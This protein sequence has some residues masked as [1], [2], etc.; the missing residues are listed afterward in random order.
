MSEKSYAPLSSTVV[1]LSY[2]CDLSDSAILMFFIPS[3]RRQIFRFVHI[4]HM[5]TAIFILI[6]TSNST[7]LV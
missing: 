6:Y 7:I 2:Y 5:Q 1:Y 3:C 4:L